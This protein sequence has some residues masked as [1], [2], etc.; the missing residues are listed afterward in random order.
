MVS[1]RKFLTTAGAAAV[2]APFAGT[3]LAGRAGAAAPPTCELALENKSL[4]GA[5]NAYVTGHEE[6]TGRWILLRGDGSRFYL[7]QSGEFQEI[8]DCSIPLKPAGSGPTVVPLP[9]MYGG[10]VYFVRDNKITFYVNSTGQLVEPSFVADA[11]VNHTK[12]WSFCE[13][14]FNTVELY[15]NLSY[16]DLVTALPIGFTL[17]GNATHTVAPL[18]LNAAE[19][20]A[21]AL[22]AQAAKDGYPWDRLVISDGGRVLRAISPQKLPPARGSFDRYWDSYTNAVWEKYASTDLRVDAGGLGVFTGRV[23]NGSLTFP[24]LDRAFAKPTSADIFSCDSGPFTNAGSRPFLAVMARLAAA[25]NRSTLLTH[26]D[27]P[28]STRPEDYYRDETTNHWSRIVHA[29]SPQGYGFPYDDV[30]PAGQRPVDGSAND[31]HPTR[32]H[33]SAG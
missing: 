22:R 11:D 9:R 6:G 5:V 28:N 15:A 18:E 8:E 33:V 20:I 13:F 7:P 24:G 26:T 12:V 30:S 19:R 31:S 17:T 32:W 29:N 14:T 1:R 25:F 2:T 21:E 10:R 16:V 23:Q 27:Q 3:L 4:P